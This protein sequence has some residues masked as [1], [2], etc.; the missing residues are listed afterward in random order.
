MLGWG[1]KDRDGRQVRLEHRGKNLRV[2]RTGGVALRTSAKAGGITWTANTNHGV[3]AS[4]R[5]AKGTNVFFQNGNFR[6]RGRYG[7]GPTKLNLSKSG[8]TVSTKNSIGTFNWVKPG[9]SSAKVGGIQV[10]GRKAVYL[11]LVLFVFQLLVWLLQAAVFLL[12]VLVRGGAL[13]VG[14]L[15]QG[16]RAVADRQRQ[17]GLEVLE[18]E[19]ETSAGDGSLPSRSALLGGLAYLLLVEGKGNPGA[20]ANPAAGLSRD[21]TR[22]RNACDEPAIADPVTRLS[23]SELAEGIALARDLLSRLPPRHGLVDA[24]ALLGHALAQSAPDNEAPTAAFLALDALCA[25]DGN[26]TVLQEHLLAAL[27]ESI[28]LEA[29]TA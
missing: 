29:L 5:V 27:A 25:A 14:W 17:R 23:A 8:V 2:S 11:H 18:N 16:W 7:R 1:R 28:G 24:T 9:R 12:V 10:R 15:G 26:R 6:L 20:S 3:R 21:L 4:K 13:L 22:L 19:L